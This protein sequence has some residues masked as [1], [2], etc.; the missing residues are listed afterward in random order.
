MTAGGVS[1][2]S[3]YPSLVDAWT[4]RTATLYRVRVDQHD[5]EDLVVKVLNDGC[6]AAALVRSMEELSECLLEDRS[7]EFLP[8]APL[9]FSDGIGGVIMPYVKGPSLAQLLQGYCL[10]SS[11]SPNDIAGLVARCGRLLGRYHTRFA[12]ESG[13][14]MAAA[15]RDLEFRV[16]KVFG[17]ATIARR[18]LKPS[19]ISRTYGDFHPGH[20]IVA[21]DQRLTLLDPPLERSYTFVARDIAWFIYNLRMF[22]LAPRSALV[23]PRRVY[24]GDELSTAFLRGYADECAGTLTRDDQITI[25]VYLAYLLKR[26]LYTLL[27]ERK[28]ARLL[29]YGVPL[30]SHYRRL[31]KRLW[32]TVGASTRRWRS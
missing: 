4:S 21:R 22:L 16:K 25:D 12:V 5:G 15:W 6:E 32:A 11:A 1:F 18:V 14:G 3:G 20:I 23:A 29:Y 26:R 2:P 10:D 31:M 9:G 19:L 30:V 13:C 27:R 24:S 28:V 8:L 7:G 17:T